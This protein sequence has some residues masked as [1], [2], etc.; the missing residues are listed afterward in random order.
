[1]SCT[2]KTI[3]RISAEEEA[4]D[5]DGRSGQEPAALVDG[6]VGP[7]AAQDPEWDG[8]HQR[9]D[10][11]REDEREG[12]RHPLAEVVD[13]RGVAGVGVTEV[14]LHGVGEPAPVLGE[15]RV[16]EVEVLAGLRDGL[17]R[18]RL[19]AGS[20][21]GRVAR[22]QLHQEED[23]EGDHEEGG[24]ERQQPSSDQPKHRVVTSP[25]T[26]LDRTVHRTRT[27]RTRAGSG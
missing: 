8:E 9:E 16:V 23:A 27:P 6:S 3:T 14:A 2:A 24:D 18:G 12:D 1:M 4:R 15:H 11:R 19:A 5:R 26:A 21:D 13:H 17:R 20:H 7:E 25:S 10:G 22:Q